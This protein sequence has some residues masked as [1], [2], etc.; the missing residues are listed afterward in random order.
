MPRYTLVCSEDLGQEIESLAREHGIRE[1][2]VLR[3]LVQRGLES[4]E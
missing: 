2:E 3:Q 4:L 1:A